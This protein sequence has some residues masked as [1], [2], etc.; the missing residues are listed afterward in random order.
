MSNPGSKKNEASRLAWKARGV[1]E[2]KNNLHVELEQQ[3]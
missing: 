1:L 3:P 2:V